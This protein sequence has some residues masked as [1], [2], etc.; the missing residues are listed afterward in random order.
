MSDFFMI[1]DAPEK[2]HGFKVG[3]LVYYGNPEQKNRAKVV[4]VLPNAV[5]I[6]L[7]I[8]TSPTVLTKI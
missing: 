6:Q 3:D 5:R 2:P 1:Q 8:V 4:A 7:E